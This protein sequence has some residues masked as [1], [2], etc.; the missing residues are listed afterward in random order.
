MDNF[1][2]GI[3]NAPTVGTSADQLFATT[4]AGSFFNTANPAG[5]TFNFP[6]TGL[7]ANSGWR[8]AAVP[9]PGTMVALG[10]GLAAL[11]ARRRRK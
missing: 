9:E 8:L 11:A 6:G 3:F 7:I 5:S 10:A 1:G 4:N 2:V